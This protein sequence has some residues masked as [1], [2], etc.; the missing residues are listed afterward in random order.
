MTA[1]IPGSFDPITLGHVNVIERAAAKFD[2]VIVAVMNNDS[3]KHDKT[4]SSKTYMFD[5][6]TRLELVRLSTK[7]IENVEVVSSSGMLID[8]F[9][10]LCA[11]VIVKGVS[12]AAMA[13]DNPEINY[14]AV[15][16][17]QDVLGDARRNIERVCGENPGNIRILCA[18]IAGIER[19]FDENDGPER[20]YISFCNP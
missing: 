14:V 20:I 7:H 3:A 15:D 11:D 8:L 17:S 18:D 16:I 13:A 19:Y 12:T 10:E 2:R 6:E 1:L 5:M 9:D 4:L